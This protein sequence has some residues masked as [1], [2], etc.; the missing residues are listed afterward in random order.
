MATPLDVGILQN[1]DVVFPMV[2]T[3][4]MV[5]GVLTKVKLFENQALNAFIAVCLAFMTVV[6]DIAIKTIN[7][8]APWMVLLMFLIIFM[9]LAFM[10][11]GV[12]EDTI[13]GVV[14]SGAYS[15]VQ[16]LVIAFVLII[17][18]GS[19]F[20]VISEEK[21]F[22]ALTEGGEDVSDEQQEFFQVLF[23]PK[24]LGFS[25]IMLIMVFAVMRLAG[26]TE[27]VF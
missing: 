14:K 10:T 5:Y 18:F 20:S 6:S 17:F 25:V 23:H 24:V 19:L 22:Q 13:T 27:K 3:F 11:F 26:P 12:K 1:F 4:V 2:F 7:R 9:M 21:G 16:N 8:S 15:V